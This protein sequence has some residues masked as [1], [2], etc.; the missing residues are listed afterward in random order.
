MTEN[1]VYAFET[2][3]SSQQL[4]QDPALLP[5]AIT[6]GETD[7]FDVHDYEPCGLSREL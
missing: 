5:A 1:S 7:I 6:I 3:C 2:V 4:D